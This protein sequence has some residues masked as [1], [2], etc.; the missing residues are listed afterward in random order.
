MFLSAGRARRL[1]VLALGVVLAAVGLGA[2]ARAAQW[3]V[4]DDGPANFGTV[5]AAVN[6]AYVH[7]GDIIL[8]R[9]G[10]YPGT[11]AVISKDL[12]IRSE[13]GPSVTVLDAQ[14]SGSVVSLQ[15]RTSA[16]R[17]EGFTITGGRDQTGGGVWIF[18]GGPVITRNVIEG[19][20]AV[21]GILGYGYG[22]GIE[23][24]SS[25][26]VIT[27]NVI[28]GNTALD[29]G[30]GID[31]YYSGP[32]TAGTCCP[33]IAQNTILDNAVTSAAGIGGGILSSASEPWI[34]SSIV[35]GNQAASGGGLYVERI[36]GINDS[37]DVTT[38]IFF[39]NAPDAAASNGN[40]R[41]PSS[42]LET[43]PR[44][45]A[46]EW[47]DVWPRS[48]S[49]A[50][51]AAEA[52]VP[53][54]ADLTGLASPVDSDMDGA[55]IDDIG[56]I[57]NRSEITGLSASTD[58][59]APGAAVLTWDDSVNPAVV[60]QV[61][62]DDMDPFALS[63]GLCLAASL[64]APTFTDGGSPPPGGI[65]FYLVTGEGAVEG[66][67]GIRSDGAPRPSAPSCSGP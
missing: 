28:R 38:N 30:G 19:N 32:S 36:Q 24:Y 46:G 35:A 43:D 6:A 57:E 15:N 49:P 10:Y 13:A 44:L 67:R 62:Q 60:F 3:I 22:G 45:G 61:Y 17:I 34:T 41:L 52:G 63:G 58:P 59:N 47:F 20:R 51:D 33:V 48:D 55:A 54:G 23:V 2:L 56:A 5:Q 64:T 12:I 65:H 50:L 37:P 31:V 14:G 53:A 9:P 29:G 39:A 16:T 27:R 11:V 7:T 8:V 21:G 40:F 1:R 42:N 18:G 66:S 4:D 25:A 26:A